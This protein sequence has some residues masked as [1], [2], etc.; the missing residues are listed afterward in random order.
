MYT[1][2]AGNLED[3]FMCYDDE[4]P[5]KSSDF[6]SGGF[7]ASLTNWHEFLQLTAPDRRCG[8]VFIRGMFPYTPD[9]ILARVQCRDRAGGKGTFGIQLI[10]D[11]DSEFELGEVVVRGLINYRWPHMQYVLHCKSFEVGFFETC[12]FVE[13]NVVYQVARICPGEKRTKESTNSIKA[14]EMGPPE[15]PREADIGPPFKRIARFRIGGTLSFGCRCTSRVT[16]DSLPKYRYTVDQREEIGLISCKILDENSNCR[17]QG[18]HQ[19]QG[20]LN[21]QLFVDGN[22]RAMNLNQKS[23]NAVKLNGKIAKE[24]VNDQDI[25]DN[26]GSLSER[27]DLFDVQDI[28]LEA[29]KECVLIFGLLS[30]QRN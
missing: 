22:I 27:V 15:Q 30:D 14:N 10:Y 2:N 23:E 19:G 3:Y 1:Y 25:G 6:S 18:S 21:M 8:T 9:S 20:C 11:V 16:S 5:A 12:S 26:Q 17:S 28:E 24:G 29:E 7:T 13:K 4:Y